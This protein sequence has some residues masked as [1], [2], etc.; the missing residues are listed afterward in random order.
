MVTHGNSGSRY[1]AAWKWMATGGW[2]DQ[3]SIEARTRKSLH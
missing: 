1:I 3:Q 2:Q